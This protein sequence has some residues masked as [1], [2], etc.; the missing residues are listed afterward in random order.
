MADLLERSKAD[1]AQSSLAKS[2]FGARR[3]C[4]ILAFQH[5]EAHRNTSTENRRPGTGGHSA[6]AYPVSFAG[7]LLRSSFSYWR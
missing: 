5:L 1:F 7:A 4:T 2:R 3:V 6:F